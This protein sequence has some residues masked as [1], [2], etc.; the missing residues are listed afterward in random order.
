MC[1][2]VMEQ[3][4]KQDCK[5]EK[6]KGWKDF[7]RGPFIMNKFKEVRMG[8]IMCKDARYGYADMAHCI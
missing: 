3:I 2:Y 5:N 1:K 7:C 4:E 6:W 8:E